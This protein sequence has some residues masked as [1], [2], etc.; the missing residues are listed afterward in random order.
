MRRNLATAV[1]PHLAYKPLNFLSNLIVKARNNPD[2]AAAVATGYGL[3]S[4]QLIIQVLLIPLYL[5]TL[6]TYTFGVLMIL[7]AQVAFG[8][9]FAGWLYNLLL[10]RFGESLA[11]GDTA[12]FS[13]LYVGGKV[14]LVGIGL[15]WGLGLL[16]LEV[17]HP[18]FFEDAPPEMQRE[19]LWAMCL[20]ALHL[21]LMYEV[22]VE[23]T[24][25]AATKRQLVS[26]SV[27]IISLLGFALC[28]VPW[29]LFGGGLIGVVGCFLVGDVAARIVAFVALRRTG[30][31][32]NIRSAIGAKTKLWADMLAPHG[33]RYFVYALLAMALQA[34][35]LVVGFFGDPNLVAQFAL[36]WKIAEIMI[37]LL[38]RIAQHLQPEFVSMDV[39]GD[40]KRLQRVYGEAYLWMG[41]A[42]VVLAV[43]YAAVGAQVVELWVGAER[44]PHETWLYPLAGAVIFWLG[45][46]RLPAILAQALSRMRPLMWI[47][48]MELSGKLVFIGYYF[49]EL[50][51]KTTLLATSLVHVCGIALAY[52]LLGRRLLG[53]WP[54]SSALGVTVSAS[55]EA[56][57][58]DRASAAEQRL[59]RR[60]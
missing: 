39:T 40:R 60:R 32:I 59:K 10:R 51:T 20:S 16:A 34:D 55:A 37:L 23:H 25:F 53:L 2:Y 24:I 42:A 18:I 38:A 14:L 4:L 57:A 8:Y 7:M 1:P 19:I 22:V 5:R 49:D 28:V 15:A 50:G 11:A 29:L 30:V 47:A 12:G 58:R 17:F 13:R 43:I 31:H 45:I 3:M 33:R 21:L 41:L 48:V 36:V 6:G 26:N 46:S 52:W 44:V 27:T 56:A 35:L 9:V 54:F